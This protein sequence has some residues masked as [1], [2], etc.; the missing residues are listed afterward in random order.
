MLLT[1]PVKVSKTAFKKMILQLVDSGYPVCMM[2]KGKSVW[3][4]KICIGEIMPHGAWVYP[5]AFAKFND[6]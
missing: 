3:I 6:N 5:A 2:D 1:V 4:D